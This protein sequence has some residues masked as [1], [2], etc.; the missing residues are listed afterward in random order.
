MAGPLERL[1]N[2]ASVQRPFGSVLSVR[3]RPSHAPFLAKAFALAAAVKILLALAGGWLWLREL[4]AS[5]GGS[6]FGSV[7]FSLSFVMFP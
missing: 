2:A 1:R 3:P 4:G 5:R 7:V 6:L